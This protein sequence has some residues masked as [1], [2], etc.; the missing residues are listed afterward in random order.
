VILGGLEILLSATGTEQ[1]YRRDALGGWQ[2]QAGMSNHRM[3]GTREPHDFVLS[4]NPDGLRTRHTPHKESSSWRIAL[5]GDSNV[6]GWGVDDEDTLAAH[7]EQAL[8]AAGETDAQV[9][10]AGQPGHSTTQMRWLFEEV[11][12]VYQPDLLLLVPS[13]HD[14]NQAH[15]SDAEALEGAQGPVAALRVGLARHSRVYAALASFLSPL[16]GEPQLLPD[17]EG[18]LRVDRVSDAERTANL[19]RI[20]SGLEPWGGQLAIALL[21]FHS[22]LSH[23]Q[24]DKPPSRPGE[25]WARAHAKARALDLVDVRTCCGPDAESLVFSFDPGHLNAQGLEKVGAA[26]ADA[27]RR[28]PSGASSP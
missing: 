18:V 14:H 11:L 23:P 2:V 19:D 13:L 8:H 5:M 4:T 20:A 17:Q 6:F 22:D 10:N 15:V 16:S 21:P 1:L 25:D 12:A 7:L 27:I 28:S 24:G 9:I 3:R 26:L